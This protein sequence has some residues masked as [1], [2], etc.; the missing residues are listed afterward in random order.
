MAFAV[1]ISPAL[2]S[3]QAT[4]QKS[5]AADPAKGA[6]LYS[7]GDPARG[8]TACIPSKSN[9]KIPIPHD[10]VLYRQRHRIE[11]MFGKLKDWRRIATRYDKLA[12]N[13]LSAAYLVAVL[14]YWVN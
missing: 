12:R 10:T 5:A 11:N 14:A 3:A 13:F 9:R 7:G 8:I 1:L 4:E 2:V 6:T